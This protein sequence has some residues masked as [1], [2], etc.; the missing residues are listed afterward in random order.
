[1]WKIKEVS[2]R[3][4]LLGVPTAAERVNLARQKKQQ[5]DIK[6]WF[7]HKVGSLQHLTEGQLDIDH[8]DTADLLAETPTTHLHMTQ[9][10]QTAVTPSEPP[11]PTVVQRRTITIL[12]FFPLT[13]NNS[14]KMIA[15]NPLPNG[16]A[17]FLR[18]LRLESDMDLDLSWLAS[19]E[20]AVLEHGPR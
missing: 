6:K 2:R 7:K 4:T 11:P 1:M 3:E 20:K 16:T 5:V 17:P 9:L 15:K 12:D 10:R 19:K 8:S 18:C 13:K 14:K